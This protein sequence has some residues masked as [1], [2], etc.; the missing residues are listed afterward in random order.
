MNQNI[1]SYSTKKIQTSD[2]LNNKFLS[3]TW[4]ILKE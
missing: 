3:D 2:E 1:K 4:Q